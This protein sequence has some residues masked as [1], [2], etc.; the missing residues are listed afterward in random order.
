MGPDSDGEGSSVAFVQRS[1]T[2]GAVS[3]NHYTPRSHDDNNPPA[4]EQASSDAQ[5]R[6]GIREGLYTRYY[7]QTDPKSAQL[8]KGCAGRASLGSALGVLI[9]RPWF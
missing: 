4:P 8:G 9:S 7:V 3:I 5:M 6:L 1:S 2:A